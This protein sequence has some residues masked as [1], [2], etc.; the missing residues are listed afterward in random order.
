[1]KASVFS[2]K[3]ISSIS[4]STNAILIFYYLLLKF[5]N[6]VLGPEQ[7]MPEAQGPLAIRV[8]TGED[9]A[10]LLVEAPLPYT[11]ARAMPQQ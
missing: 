4:Y 7:S 1:M 3:I 9:T 10:A 11:C 5:S 2:L 8:H 6:L